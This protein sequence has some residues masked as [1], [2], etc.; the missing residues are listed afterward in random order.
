MHGALHWCLH[1]SKIGYFV[2][3]A[4]YLLPIPRD[5]IFFLM[6]VTLFDHYDGIY[7][8]DHVS[9]HIHVILLNTILYLVGR[10]L[11]FSHLLGR[12]RYR[13]QCCHME[14]DNL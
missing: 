11:S 14:I 10:M 9:S 8:S 5:L 2:L 7:L 1:T 4:S 3:M 12:S 13:D 6:S